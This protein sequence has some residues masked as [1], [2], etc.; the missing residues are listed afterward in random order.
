MEN[1]KK[2]SSAASSMKTGI[3][4]EFNNYDQISLTAPHKGKVGALRTAEQLCIS[5]LLMLP[6]ITGT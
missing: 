1:V 3:K 6:L 2:Y 5:L 4:H